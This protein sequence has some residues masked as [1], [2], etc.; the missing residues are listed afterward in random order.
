MKKVLSLIL[1]VLM[2][3]PLLCSCDL[4]DKGSD[5][6]GPTLSRGETTENAYINQS[7]GITFT[8]PEGWRFYTDAEIASLMDISVDMFRDKD[9][10][11]T[12]ELTSAIDFMAINTPVGDNVNMSIENLKFSNSTSLT[13]AQ[14]I[15]KLKTLLTEQLPQAKYN[16]E[17]QGT[18]KLGQ[19]DFFRLEASCSYE[20]INM[21]QY[22]YLIKA[23]TYMV[24]ITATTVRDTPAATF[25]AMFS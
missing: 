7:L 5:N 3:S 17:E 16:F 20:G 9:L 8:L 23:G 2:L 25:E 13:V 22:I 11:E 24:A 18:V 14:Y 4:F 21:T 1:A 10:F 6:S 19:T 15:P 12:A